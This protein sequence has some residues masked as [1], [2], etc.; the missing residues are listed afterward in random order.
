MK[1][2]KFNILVLLL[3]L[4]SMI[5]ITCLTYFL[6]AIFEKVH[7]LM[8]L[9]EVTFFIL[10]SLITFRHF[11]KG[12]LF[13]KI[14]ILTIF[15]ICVSCMTYMLSIIFAFHFSSNRFT[16]EICADSFSSYTFKKN[17]FYKYYEF[18]LLV[19]DHMEYGTYYYKDNS[20]I[21]NPLL[22]TGK[23]YSTKNY[24]LSNEKVKRPK[25]NFEWFKKNYDSK[26]NILTVTDN[27]GCQIKRV[28][29]NPVDTLLFR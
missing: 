23:Y 3:K 19:P 20:F 5:I 28:F 12:P 6:E 13:Q 29:Y 9:T 22:I 2:K 21:L 17:G 27:Y 7:W 15:I 14:S 10:V 1:S 18:E 16:E 24:I 25:N 26:T 4:L 11:N 8:Y